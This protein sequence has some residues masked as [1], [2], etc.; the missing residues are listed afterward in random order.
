M[1][2]AGSVSATFDMQFGRALFLVAARARHVAGKW[3]RLILTA[4]GDYVTEW[5][6]DADETAVYASAVYVAWGP[7]RFR[8]QAVDYYED[9]RT[10]EDRGIEVEG[11]CVLQG[12]TA[13]AVSRRARITPNEFAA[14][15]AGA[16]QQPPHE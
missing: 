8:L 12:H 1:R 6:I 11:M 14:L 2:R 7:V 4:N 3:P 15:V 10:G 5:R 13:S 9:P 16:T